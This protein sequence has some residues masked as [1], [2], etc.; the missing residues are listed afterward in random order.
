MRDQFPITKEYIF[1]DVANKNA[2]PIPVTSVIADYLYKQQT[3]G[4]NKDEWKKTMEEARVNLARLINGCPEEIAFTKNTSE[5]LNIAANGIPFRP[6]DN[7]ILNDNEHP[8]NIYCWLN[9]ADKGVK[10]RWAPSK[11]GMVMADDIEQLIDN[12]TRAVSV[13]FVTFMPGNRNDITAISKVCRAKGIYLVVDVVQGL[14]ILDVDVVKLGIDMFAAS[15]HKG[16]LSPHGIGVFYCRKEV[17]DQI[18]PTYVARGSMIAPVAIEHDKLD[19]KLLLSD[20][21][22][23][24]EI[25]NHNYLGITALNEGLKF[26][27]AIGINI[28]KKRVLELSGYLSERLTALGVELLSPTEELY[29]SGIVCFRTADT[30]GLYRWLQQNKVIVSY[31]R[32]SIRASLHFYNTKEEIDRF[33]QLIRDFLF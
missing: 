14:G 18:K 8:N 2:L 20:V 33:L 9:L 4:G 10:V 7:V 28:I 32:D 26:I 30:A 13:S 17:M 12:S 1:F 6:G 19:Y 5:G 3:T 21:A 22:T 24:Y 25:G 29:R 16:L 15:G 27:N 23:R 31:R 11:K